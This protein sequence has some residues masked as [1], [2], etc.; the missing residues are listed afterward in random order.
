MNKKVVVYEKEEFDLS[1]DTKGTLVGLIEELTNLKQLIPEE[2]IEDTQISLETYT[3]SYSCYIDVEIYYYRPETEEEEIERI[4]KHR[5]EM[6][7]KLRKE[8]EEYER[9]K[10]KLRSAYERYNSIRNKNK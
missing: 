1:Y 8:K 5:E 9:L 6:L 2:Y 7:A 4:N 10:A 3:D